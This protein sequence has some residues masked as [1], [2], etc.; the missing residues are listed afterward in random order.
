MDM[1]LEAEGL[2]IE[3]EAALAPLQF[4]G[5]AKIIKPYLKN[6]HEHHYS[7][8]LEFKYARIER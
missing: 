2:L 5:N 4:Q 8:A 7:P 6:Y 1:P 3:E